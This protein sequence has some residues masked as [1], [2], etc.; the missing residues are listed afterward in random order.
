MTRDPGVGLVYAGFI[1]MIAGFFITFF[2]SHQR[3]CVA[4]I[5]EKDQVRVEVSGMANKNQLGMQ[6]KTEK[7]SREIQKRLTGT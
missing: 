7:L 5:S 4:L 3:V 2:M 6:R 1:I